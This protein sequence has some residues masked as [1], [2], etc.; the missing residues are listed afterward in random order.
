MLDFLYRQSV[1][2]DLV[3]LADT[4]YPVRPNG[5]PLEPIATTT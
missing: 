1:S 2:N 3:W 5:I 4:P